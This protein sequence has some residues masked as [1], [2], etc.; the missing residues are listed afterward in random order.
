[1]GKNL[2]NVFAFIFI[3]L[4][5]ALGTAA[6]YAISLLCLSISDGLPLGTICINTLG[7]FII[8]FFG[9]LTLT[10]GK[11]QVSEAAR[12]FV[13]VVLCGGFPHSQPSVCK[14]LICCN[15][16]QLCVRS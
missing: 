2:N 8:G 16:G 12:L 4:G 15:R 3:S 10:D 14:T 11:Y 9:T 1:M 6:R 13:M 7:S 5:D